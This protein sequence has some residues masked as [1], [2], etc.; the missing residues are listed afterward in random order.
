MN[1]LH[2]FNLWKTCIWFKDTGIV[3]DKIKTYL[4]I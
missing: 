1:W 3:D 2:V 4:Y